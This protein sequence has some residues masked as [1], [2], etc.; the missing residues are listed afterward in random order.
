[1]LICMVILMEYKD[2]GLVFGWPAAEHD[3]KISKKFRLN[4]RPME[5]VRRYHGYAFAWAAIY[6]FWYHPM[7]NTIG[8]A[9]GFFY[10]WIILLQ[11]KFVRIF[12]FFVLKYAMAGIQ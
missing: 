10:T 11:G 9:V 3:G 2:R 4:I 1:M 8:H 12:S 7:E 5:L 6:T